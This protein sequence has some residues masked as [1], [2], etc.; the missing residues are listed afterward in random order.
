M[1]QVGTESADSDSKSGSDEMD[2]FIDAM[3]SDSIEF[4]SS[5]DDSG[6]GNNGSSDY[7]DGSDYSEMGYAS[8]D[9]DLGLTDSFS[10][11]G[12]IDCTDISVGND[13]TYCLRD[14]VCSGEG[15]AP[16]GYACPLKDD[17]AVTDCH[18]GMRSFL[19]GECVAPRDSICQKAGGGSWGCV[20][21]DEL[22]SNEDVETTSFSGDTSTASSTETSA[23][24]DECKN[25]R[26]GGDATFCI[27]GAV[28]SGNG[29]SPAGNRCPAVGDVAVG[30]CHDYFASYTSSSGK[31]VAASDAACVRA[32]SGTW[33]CVWSGNDNAASNT[34]G[35]SDGNATEAST[36]T[37]PV[38]TGIAIAAAI[39]TVIAGIAIAWSRHKRR[40]QHRRPTEERTGFPLT[41][42]GSARG[43]FHR[44]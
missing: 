39:G 17:V 31:C 5:D 15:D 29:D 38:V 23:E 43:S 13:A 24:I 30:D 34:I 3:S 11:S 22:A 10:T 6:T 12:S 26:V 41:P 33:G 27:K 1:S 2:V 42:L 32:S 14:Q 8:D 18:D 16:T 21:E 44:V 40:N 37:S 35:T 9:S 20:W 4:S 19:N 7:S 28:C 25:I 36:G